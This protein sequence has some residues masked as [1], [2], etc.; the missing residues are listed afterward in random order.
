[1][2]DKQHNGTWVR[3]WV[4]A[5]MAG[6]FLAMAHGTMAQATPRPPER[7]TYQGFLT[8]ADGVALG[9]SA[10]KAYDVL[11]RIYDSEGSNTPLWGEQQTVTVDKGYFSVLLGEGAPVSGAPNAGVSLS[12]LFNGATASDRYVGF[13]V[14]GIGAN[15]SDVDILP[16]VRFMSSAYAFLASR[17]ILANAAVKLVQD[18]ATGADLLS[19]TG[20][21]L[22]LNG[23]LGVTGGNVLEFGYGVSGKPGDNGKIGYGTFSGDSLDIVGAGSTVNNRKVRF[24]SPGEV[25][26]DGPITAPSVSLSGDLTVGGALNVNGAIQMSGD[27]SVNRVI[28]NESRINN[29]GGLVFGVGRTKANFW[30]G[31]INYDSVNGFDRLRILGGG[32]SDAERRVIMWAEGGFE[33]VGEMSARWGSGIT[34]DGGNG[35]SDSASATISVGRF[36]T[37]GRVD[38]VGGGPPNTG[39]RRIT[40]HNQAG[41]TMHGNLWIAGQQNNGSYPLEV[42]GYQ[43]FLSWNVGIK[44]DYTVVSGGFVQWSDERLKNVIGPSAASK[45][46]EI[47]RKLRVTDYSLKD[48][49]MSTRMPVKG[50]LAQELRELLPGAVGELQRVLPNIQQ[51]ADTV[52]WKG[53]GTP[54]EVHL[55][56]AH[57]LKKGDVVQVELD[58]GIHQSDVEA[59]RDEQTFSV[60]GV[61]TEPKTARVIGKRESGV[62]A[63]DYQQVYM[64]AISA[65]QEVDRRLVLVEKREARMAELESK[66]TR[67]EALERDLAELRKLVLSIPGASGKAKQSASSG[68]AGGELGHPS[69]RQVV[70]SK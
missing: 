1:M 31:S 35:K 37:D 51:T 9:N 3:R 60:T 27:I 8:G 7:M 23:N 18:N 63:V 25:T 15:G 22:T 21:Q 5:A 14:K 43:N 11:F 66:A 69:D 46:M 39:Q 17:S 59:V 16:R 10:P 54:L 49:T 48:K 41:A 33:L 68:D 32:A 6:A 26:F 42:G 12:S 34:F 57:G 2:Q 64:T 28:A 56:V 53:A 4:S 29:T 61:A 65:L 30:N 20:S 38:I 50:V 13:T 36:S 58:G 47:I 62:L 45:D 70:L 52:S 44:A 19:G 55:P 40:F 24:Y 67:V